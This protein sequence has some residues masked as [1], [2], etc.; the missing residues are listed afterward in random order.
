MLMSRQGRAMIRK[1]HKKIDYIIQHRVMFTIN[2]LC[3]ISIILLL[4]GKFPMYGLTLK[5]PI[6]STAEHEHCTYDNSF[7]VKGEKVDGKYDPNKGTSLEA[8]D[9]RATGGAIT[10]TYFIN[11]GIQYQGG[12]ISW[13]RVEYGLDED[14]DSTYPWGMFQ[15]IESGMTISPDYANK[16]LNLMGAYVDIDGVHNVADS[17]I[18]RIKQEILKGLVTCKEEKQ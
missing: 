15:F 10:G 11:E 6:K 17:E 12:A 4:I 8:K 5:G 16:R 14:G 9:V 7:I 18:E 2:L 3:L 13:G 1:R